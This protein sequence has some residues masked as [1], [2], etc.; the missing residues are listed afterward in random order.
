MPAVHTLPVLTQVQ[1]IGLQNLVHAAERGRIGSILSVYL[2]VKSAA[3]VVL[4]AGT[5]NGGILLVAVDEELDLTFAP[6]AAVVD[7]ITHGNTHIVA[8]PLDSV[9]NSILL[10]IG[11]RVGSAELGVEIRAVL[12]NFRQGIIDLI[13]AIGGVLGMPIFNCDPGMLAERHFPEAVETT[14]GIHRHGKAVNMYIG[15]AL[16]ILSVLQREVYT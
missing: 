11:Q 3:E 12:R 10:A 16:G 13:E 14:V 1:A 5:A 4:G 7:T 2:P 8:I 15:T 9:Q 6:P